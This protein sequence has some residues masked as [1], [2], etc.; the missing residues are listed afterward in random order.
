VKPRSIKIVVASEYPIFRIGVA[1]LFKGST[2][3][4]VG[5][6]AS[7][8][9]TVSAIRRTKPDVLLIDLALRD[10]TSPECLTE[11]K[12]SR[13]D[14][15]IIVVVSP[16]RAAYLLHAIKLGC[17]G[18]V[19]KEVTAR[20][21]IQ[22]VRAVAS[23][24]RVLEPGL[25]SELVGEVDK[26]P[27]TTESETAEALSVTELEVLRLIARGQTNRQIAHRLGY[28]LGT[29]KSYV[30][31]IMRKLG[32]ADRVQAAVR[33]ARCGLD[34]EPSDA[35]TAGLRARPPEAASTGLPGHPAS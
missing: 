10:N 24:E 12:S 18:F 35:A 3:R 16:E 13:P 29:V 17:V 14:T 11:I 4:V 2:V 33:A 28:R 26:R 6:A 9:E 25:L 7:V 23:G 5:E 15:R 20:R 31:R 22:A 30:Q 32:V 8:S 21:L 19:T 27:S 34:Q 1:A